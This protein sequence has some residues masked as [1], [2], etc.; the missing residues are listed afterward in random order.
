MAIPVRRT[1]SIF[2]GRRVWQ[3]AEAIFGVFV[4]GKTP[5]TGTSTRRSSTP[6]GKSVERRA[7]R[8]HARQRPPDE[9]SC[10]GNFLRA[11]QRRI[12]SAQQSRRQLSGG[13]FVDQSGQPWLCCPGVRLAACATLDELQRRWRGMHR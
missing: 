10:R 7:G 1:E 2:G 8:G 4:F 3:D 5:G 11:A 12:A 9:E 6:S 13:R